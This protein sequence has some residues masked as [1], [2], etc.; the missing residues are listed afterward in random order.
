MALGPTATVLAWDLFQAGY[1]AVD[2]GHIDLEYEWMR[3]GA[4]EKVKVAGKYVNEVA[5]GDQV[6]DLVD[7]AYAAQ[8]VGKVG[9]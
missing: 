8:I 5:G 2:A 6:E 3:L 4:T 7:E 9:L 1:W